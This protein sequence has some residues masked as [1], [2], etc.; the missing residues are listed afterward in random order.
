MLLEYARLREDHRLWGQRFGTNQPT[1]EV[2]GNRVRNLPDSVAPQHAGV[3]VQQIAL[4][5]S[6][7]VFPV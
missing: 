6:A 2:L 1:T 5:C 4:S 3:L 7:Q